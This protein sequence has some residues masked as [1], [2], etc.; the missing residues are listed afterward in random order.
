MMIR[1]G[2]Y[3]LLAG[4]FVGIF[5]GISQ[6]MG[7]KN[8]WVDLTISKIIGQGASDSMIGFIPILAIKNS[9]DYLIYS[10]PFFIF[11]LGLSLIFFSISLFLK[12]H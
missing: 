3:A 9:L 7:S 4:A 10:L 11:L 1:L 12:N 2:I 6:L 8:F 5:K